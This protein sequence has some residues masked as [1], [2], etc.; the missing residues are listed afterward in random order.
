MKPALL[1]RCVALGAACIV[2]CNGGASDKPSSVG[3]SGPGAGGGTAGNAAG[4]APIF[5]TSPL[6]SQ[7]DIHRLNR[8]EYANTIRDLTGVQFD[9]SSLLVDSSSLGFDNISSIQTTT[10]GHVEAYLAAA[11]RI[12]DAI[13]DQAPTDVKLRYE[14]DSTDVGKFGGQDHR[15]LIKDLGDG[16][17]CPFQQRLSL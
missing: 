7:S 13:I 8:A 3:A 16:F 12:A 4:S 15:D 17:V 9:P 6:T 14:A 5:D 10:P 2:G 1:G 11:E